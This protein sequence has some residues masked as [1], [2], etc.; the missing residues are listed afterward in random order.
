MHTIK[1]WELD[2]TD[3]LEDAVMMFCHGVE[4]EKMSWTQSTCTFVMQ[5]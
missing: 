2:T 5:R 4:R 3:F 1:L